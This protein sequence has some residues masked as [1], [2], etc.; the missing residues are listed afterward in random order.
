MIERTFPVPK[1]AEFFVARNVQLRPIEIMEIPLL[2][3]FLYEA[4]FIP[5]GVPA[6]PRSIIDNEELQVYVRDFG[7]RKDDRCIVAECDG[8]GVGAVWTRIMDDYGNVADD[9]P[10]L[11][12]SLYREY[13]NRGIGTALLERMLELLRNDGY[14]QVSL[15]VQKAN[16]AVRMYRKV[17]FVMEKETEE[18]YIMVC[19]LQKEE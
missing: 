17:G 14:K 7:Q 9:T 13:R 5:E 11:A 2:D 15:S 16:Y 1:Q 12:M 3:D 4:I 8:K 18:E 10:S 6:P 19:N